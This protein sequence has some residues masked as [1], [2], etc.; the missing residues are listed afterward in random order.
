MKRIQAMMMMGWF[1]FL[2]AAAM[3]DEGAFYGLLRVR[4]LSP[5]GNLRLDMRPAHA[6]SIEPG[7]WAFETEIDYQNTW[8]LSEETEAYLVG[9]EAD[10]RRPLGPADVQAIRDLPGENYLL[11]F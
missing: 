9:R 6:V 5:F 4:D 2:S 7:T 3:A 8:A 11:D 1:T 10:G